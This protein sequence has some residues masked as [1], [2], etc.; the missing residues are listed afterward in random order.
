MCYPF[1]PPKTV[2]NKGVVSW[3]KDKLFRDGVY[4]FHISYQQHP[5]RDK[6]TSEFNIIRNS[7]KCYMMMSGNIATL[8]AIVEQKSYIKR[9]WVRLNVCN[10]R[11]SRLGSLLTQGLCCIL[12]NE[13][14]CN[15]KCIHFIRTNSL[16]KSAMYTGTCSCLN[17]YGAK[18]E[19]VLDT[20]SRFQ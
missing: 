10:F 7:V 12:A 19:L 6:L 9:P 16:L 18:I 4:M 15:R 1:C 13:I 3:Q 8:I 14:S 17:V 5:Y 20:L 2:H 11:R